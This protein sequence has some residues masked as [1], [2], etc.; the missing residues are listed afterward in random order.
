[1]SK[2]YIEK[3]GL[4]FYYKNYKKNDWKVISRRSSKKIKIYNF[5][6]ANSA[7]FKSIYIRVTYKRGIYNDG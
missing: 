6:Q 4:V 1:M 2:R 3:N 7:R 5:P